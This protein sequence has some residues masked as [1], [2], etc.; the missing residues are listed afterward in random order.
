MA[1]NEEVLELSVE[2]VLAAEDVAEGII[3][4]PVPE[5]KKN[6]KGGFVYLRPM[7]AFDTVQFNRELRTGKLKDDSMIALFS[8]S[9]CDSHGDLL[10]KTKNQLDGLL[11]KSTAVFV[12]AQNKIMQMNGMQT[13][14]KNWEQLQPLLEKAGVDASI[15]KRIQTDWETPEEQVKNN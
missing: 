4:F 1:E 14:S 13:S 2:D 15:I 8:K 9:A 3:K 6:G 11:E 7:S 10:F 12:R 5:W